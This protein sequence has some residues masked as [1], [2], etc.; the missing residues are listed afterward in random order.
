MG[1]L[2]PNLKREDHVIVVDMFPLDSIFCVIVVDWSNI[3]YTDV[4]LLNINVLFFV[5]GVDH[6]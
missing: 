1:M 3:H 4:P 2:N 6:K 5:I